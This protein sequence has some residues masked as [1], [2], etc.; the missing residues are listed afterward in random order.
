MSAKPN[1]E[2]VK[3][4]FIFKRDNNEYDINLKPIKEWLNQASTYVSKV[5][6]ISKKDA[7]IEIKNVLKNVKTNNPIVKYKFRK[8]NGD[9]EIREEKLTDYIKDVLSN[10]EVIVPSFTTYLHP[11]VKKS[12]HADFL[13]IN[14]AKRKADKHN[15]FKFKQLGDMDKYLYFNTMQKVRKIFNNSLSGAYASKSTALFNPSAHYTLTSITRSVASIGNAVSE[16]IIAGNKHFKSPEI[17]I[18]YITAIISNIHENSVEYV[19]NKYKLYVPTAQ[20]VMDSIIYSSK[21]YWRDE[22]AEK[23]IFSYLQT[24]TDAERAAVL[25]TNDLWHLKKHN[26]DFVKDMLS[27]LSKKVNQ[28]SV[29]NIKDLNNSAEGINNLVHHICIE[30]IQG[31]SVNYKDLEKDN[32]ELLSTL[33]STARNLTLELQYF[34]RLFRVF[35][36]TNILPPTIAYIKDMMRDAIVLS[37]TDST[38]G[39]YD[40]W[41]EW[42]FGAPRFSAEAIGLS[43]AVMTINTQVIDHNLKLFAKNMNI[44]SSL[45]ELLKMKNEFFWPVFTAT[46]VSKHYFADTLIQEG[47]VFSKPDLE[48]KG[49][50]LI[51]SAVDQ[52]TVKQIHAMISEI[53]ARVT[54]GEKISLHHYAKKIA[55]LERELINRVKSGDISIF[56][57]DKIKEANSYKLGKEKSPYI[58]HMMWEEVFMDKYGSPGK[59]TY[60]VIK[61]PTTLKSNKNLTEF[62]ENIKD[63]QI[64]DDLTKFLNKHGKTALGTFRPPVSI[65]ATKGIPEEFIDVIDVNRIVLDSLNA[66]YLVLESIG[67]YRKPDKLISEMGY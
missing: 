53:D 45:V 12:I 43:A 29:D 4:E 34:K 9:T 33:A 64:K 16:S 51:A 63:H 60:M 36:T 48:L 19:L 1:P 6:G 25:Y 27:R 44:E 30:E 55:D 46:N 39:S 15:A 58:N 47:N 28:G 20:D 56:K 37:D 24:L 10:G 31:L 8:E 18:N 49:V 42:Y 41:V 57:K 26:L 67:F 38:C 23:K 2:I 3:D 52:K 22:V 61:I 17:V 35:F 62:L 32:P 59:P 13:S 21:Y 11:S 65:V 54:N 50:H 14:I 40:K 7:K 66:G 5:N